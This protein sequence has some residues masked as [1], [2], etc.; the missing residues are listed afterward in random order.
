MTAA[1]VGG[2]QDRLS[3]HEGGSDL[4][5]GPGNPTRNRRGEAKSAEGRCD[6]RRA[7]PCSRWYTPGGAREGGVPRAACAERNSRSGAERRYSR[8]EA[9]SGCVVPRVYRGMVERS[10]CVTGRDAGYTDRAA[11]SLRRRYVCSLL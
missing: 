4:Y 11:S 3:D 6:I 10:V 5:L 9:A 7:G 2:H 1:S 8:R